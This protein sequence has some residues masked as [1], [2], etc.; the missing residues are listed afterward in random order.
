MNYSNYDYD[1]AKKAWKRKEKCILYIN[2]IGTDADNTLNTIF[3][4]LALINPRVKKSKFGNMNATKYSFEFR[5]RI[6]LELMK[7][8]IRAIIHNE[9]R[10]VKLLTENSCNWYV[11]NQI[12][13]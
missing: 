9:F 3:I 8:N 1:R 5:D 4:R 6:A 11:I 2:S 10:N 13:Y 12:Y 7:K